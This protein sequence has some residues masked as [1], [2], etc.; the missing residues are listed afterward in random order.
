MPISAESV[1]KLFIEQVKRPIDPALTEH[2]VGLLSPFIDG[3]NMIEVPMEV[4]PSIVFQP[5]ER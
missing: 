1:Q 5:I 2:V 3:L 4:Q